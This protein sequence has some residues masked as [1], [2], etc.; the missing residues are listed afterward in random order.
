[1][2]INKPIA[3]NRFHRTLEVHIDAVVQNQDH[4]NIANDVLHLQQIQIYLWDIEIF[5]DKSRLLYEDVM[6]FY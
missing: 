2:T 1:M 5:T 3:I 4:Y 6:K